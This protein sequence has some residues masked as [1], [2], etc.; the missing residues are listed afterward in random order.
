MKQQFPLFCLFVYLKWH[1]SDASESTA[2]AG[3]SSDQLQSDKGVLQGSP[4]LTVSNSNSNVPVHQVRAFPWLQTSCPAYD[5][6]ADDRQITST[7]VTRATGEKDRK[8][9]DFRSILAIPR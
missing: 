9:L 3:R 7:L 6:A 2:V 1:R 4:S 8:I 5:A